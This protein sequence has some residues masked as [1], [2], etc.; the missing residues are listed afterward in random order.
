MHP[1]VKVWLCMPVH[2]RVHPVVTIGR[3]QRCRNGGVD[4]LQGLAAVGLVGSEIGSRMSVV[5]VFSAGAKEDSRL[6]SALNV[7]MT[8]LHAYTLLLLLM[9]VALYVGVWVK[10]AQVQVPY[11]GLGWV[12]WGACDGWCGVR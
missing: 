9:L 11:M 12:V 2:A 4:R 8:L 1:A 6:T 10:Q 5:L 3:L 7:C